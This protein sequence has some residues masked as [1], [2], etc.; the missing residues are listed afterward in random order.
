MPGCQPRM[1]AWPKLASCKGNEALEHGELP[2]L[3]EWIVLL[4]AMGLVV[5]F[6]RRLN[7]PTVLGYLLIG[8]LI[9]PFGLGLFSQSLPWLE[10]ITIR[11]TGTMRIWAE[12]GVVFLLFMI[13]L[14]L[15]MQRLLSMAR[16]VFG[17]GAAQVVITA[18]LFAG[19]LH[20]GV[21][22]ALPQAVIIGA[23]L[24]LSSTAIVMHMLVEERRLATPV[25]RTSF[26]IL[27]FQDIAVVPILFLV[28]AFAVNHAGAAQDGVG[29]WGA[30]LLNLGKAALAIIVIM[31]LGRLLVRPLLHFVAATRTRESFMAAVLLLAIGTGMATHAAGLSMALGAFLAG[32]LLAE[33]EYA[34]Q[35][36]V[37]LE[38]FKGLLMG[39]FFTSIGMNL[40]VP[41]A[42]QMIDVLLLAVAALIIL[43][44]AILVALV[45][46]FGLSGGVSL[47]TA[48]LLAHGGEFAFVIFSQA[49]QVNVLPP[50]VAQFFLVVTTVSMF[51]LP[52]L[53]RLGRWL[54]CR[55]TRAAMHRQAPMPSTE[56]SHALKDHVIIIGYGRVG[57]LLGAVL[58]ELRIP[59][60]A[61]DN[62]PVIVANCRREAPVYFGN[63]AQADMLQRLGAQRAMA[64]V[65]TTDDAD[66]AER[67]VAVAHAHWPQLPVLA[68]ARDTRHAMQLVGR[69]A[70]E[71]VPETVEA[72]LDL[73]E[74]L[75]KATGM[76]SETAHEIIATRRE[77]ERQ[78]LQ[79]AVRHERESMREG[80][81]S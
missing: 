68:R 42:L 49:M 35:V 9:G 11:D 55:H 52:F 48:L 54:A 65:V 28:G 45:R 67:I 70:H 66:A 59:F 61:L 22:L 34:H 43:K 69:G 39:V 13:G 10:W 78:R 44:A 1:C 62:D 75:L 71:V 18:L 58:S 14:E 32:L 38:P 53:A 27:L 36:E 5:P 63:A 26:A 77:Q 60:V 64:L 15:S 24:A 7:A 31:A 57:Q 47:E 41:Q 33:T 17:L 37:D 23:G 76:T 4:V 81:P 29:V 79:R 73:A 80:T 12:L 19:L 8:A 3:R 74:L 40:N 6:V 30:L 72:S 25:G 56:E 20:L 2:V 21:G 16:L 51:L 46:L 50:A